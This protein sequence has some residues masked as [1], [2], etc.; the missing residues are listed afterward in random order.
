ME[1]KSLMVYLRELSDPRK[2]KGKRHEQEVILIIIILGLMIGCKSMREIS[3]FAWEYREDLSK[4]LP[5]HRR[6]TPSLMT[7]IRTLDN[8]D[9]EELCNCFNKWMEKFITT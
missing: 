7:L 6:K 4:K 3:R 8:I 9:Q 2:E 5:L 1:S